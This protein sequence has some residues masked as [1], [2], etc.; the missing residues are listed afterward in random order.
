MTP[1]QVSVSWVPFRTEK[2]NA[3]GEIEQVKTLHEKHAELETTIELEENRPLPDDVVLQ[4][5]KR[6]KLAIKDQIASMEH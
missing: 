4:D 6:Q 3:V 2:E 1:P 5:L